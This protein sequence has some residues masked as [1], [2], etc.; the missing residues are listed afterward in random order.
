MKT[1]KIVLPETVDIDQQ[2]ALLILASKMYE[3][4]KIS[5]GQAAIMAGFSKRGFME[6]LTNYG[7]SIFNYQASDIDKDVIHAKNYHI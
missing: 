7:V 4:G 3:K 5:L 2:E 6:V 1:L